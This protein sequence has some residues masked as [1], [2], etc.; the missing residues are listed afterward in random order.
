MKIF[1][2]LGVYST[3]NV[4]K[5]ILLGCYT[6]KEEAILAFSNYTNKT[7]FLGYNILER[8]LDDPAKE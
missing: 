4:D 6:T 2:L 1:V 7:D 3:K 5:D 8:F